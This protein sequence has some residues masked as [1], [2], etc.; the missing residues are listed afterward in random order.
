MKCILLIFLLFPF[1]LFS[2]EFEIGG[3]IETKAILSTENET[4][5]WFHT[6][7]NYAVGELTNLSVT[8]ELKASLM[9]SKFKLNAGAAVYGRDGVAHNVQRRD[10]YLQFEN[11][12]LLATVGS[13]KQKEVLDGLSATNQNFLWSGNARPLPGLLIEA[14]NPFKISNTFRIDWG[15]GHYVMNDERY[16]D[17]TQLHYKRLGVITTFNENNQLTLGVQHYAQWGGT[18]PEWGKLKSGFKDF[19]NVFFAH[20]TEEYGIEGET[21]NKLG[22]HLGTL[23]LK[24]EF[25]NTLG[26]FSIY[27]D[28]YIEDGSGTRWANFPDGL[29]GI[30]FKPQNQK[31]ISSI[32]YEY[33]DTVDQSGISVGSGKDNYFSNSIYR[34]GWTYEENIIGAPFILFD[35]NVEID[36]DNTPIISN[37]SK[38][39]HFAVMGA[40]SKFQW[41]LKSTYAKYLGT[42]RKPFFPE[43]KYWYNFGSLSYESEILG[44]FTVLGGVDFS[45]VADTRVGGGIEYSY[46][47]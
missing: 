26:A 35:K 4:P 29:W 34:S 13:K 40:F 47:F 31:I 16:V 25:K 5:F 18:S 43:W 30:Y 45:N 23:L 15:I 9:Y 20:T 28:H 33:I 11:S 8:A 14:N 36:G 24:Y 22:N 19:V 38:V 17:N 27:H 37:R 6:N 44:T 39:H 3:S 12:W 2:Q 32:L 7:T 42:Y 10:L 46:S 1:L 21:L 41:K